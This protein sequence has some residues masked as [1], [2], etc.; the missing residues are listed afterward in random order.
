MNLPHEQV[1]AMNNRSM[2][3]AV[4][5]PILA[6]PDIRAAV[7]WLC[8][9]FG[10]VER[11]RIGDHRAQLSF[12]TGA[13]VVAQRRDHAGV[14][15]SEGLDYSVTVRVRDVDQHF[16]QALR[17]GAII[18]NAPTDQP[19]GERQYSAQDIGGYSWTFSETIA[20]VDPEAW[21][22]ELFEQD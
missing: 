15:S 19:Y 9:A 22:G 3:S 7:D 11:L 2:P 16:E 10:F 21:G 1:A 4:V 8:R 17:A 20:D 14:P 13:I 18:V 12:G 5:I 6:Y